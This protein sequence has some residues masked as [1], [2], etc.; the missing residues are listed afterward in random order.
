[1]NHTGSSAGDQLDLALVRG[2]VFISL[3]ATIVLRSSFLLFWKR[4]SWALLGNFTFW[5]FLLYAVTIAASILR[6]FIRAYVYSIT[7]AQVTIVF[8][9]AATLI[10]MISSLTPYRLITDYKTGGFQS[11]ERLDWG[12]LRLVIGVVALSVILLLVTITVLALQALPED[13]VL[14]VWRGLFMAN[15]CGEITLLAWVLPR[16]RFTS[17][18][19]QFKWYLCATLWMRGGIFVANILRFTSVVDSELL[20]TIHMSIVISGLV[21][22][23]WRILSKRFAKVHAKTT[24]TAALTAS[25]KRTSSALK[26]N[27][28][29]KASAVKSDLP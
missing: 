24:S 17:M 18:E 19:S 23:N 26:A 12:N 29:M 5:V 21:L 9:W 16:F 6:L 15:A 2:I 3:S 11:T 22:Y 10:V 13:T 14:I 7:E 1:M 27:K 8:N 4:L 28:T 25:K 20:S